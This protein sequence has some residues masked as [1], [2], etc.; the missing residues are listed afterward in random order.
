MD[1]NNEEVLAFTVENNYNGFSLALSLMQKLEDYP[2][3]EFAIESKHQH[4]VPFLMQQGFSV[5]CI[6]PNNLYNHR[7][8][9]VISGCQSDSVDAYLIADYLKSNRVLLV[10]IQKDSE[11]TEQIRMLSADRDI[12]VCHAS[13]LANQL[14]ATLRAYYPQALLLFSDITCYSALALWEEYPTFDAFKRASSEELVSFFKKH[15]CFSEQRM[16]SIEKAKKQKSLID[17]TTI[18]CKKHLMIALVSQLRVVKQQIKK[19]DALLDELLAEHEDA[20]WVTSLPGAGAV[21]ACKI[22]S[23]FGDDR[24]RFSSYEDVQAL[25]GAAP[26][27]VQSGKYR[28]VHFRSACS[29]PFR[30]T[31]H[32]LAF[33]SIKESEWAKAYYRKKR[34]EG[35]TH[36]HALRCLAF[37]WVKIIYT[38]WKKRELYSEEKRLASIGRHA[39]YNNN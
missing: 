24:D 25:S 17:E 22:I 3:I 14:K 32:T 20:Q 29:K 39:L 1:D 7:K 28:N 26:V 11:K 35:K 27:T 6:N 12:L 15:R 5:F 19:Y 31:M 34:E 16:K 10:P 9:I 4:V 30:D 36:N 18:E 38:L 2:E 37:I 13:R 8:S 33:C 21:I 23:R